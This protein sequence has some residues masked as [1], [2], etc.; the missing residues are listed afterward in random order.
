MRIQ[1]WTVL[2]SILA[3]HSQSTLAAP[4]E[5]VTV[6]LISQ[7]IPA[8]ISIIPPLVKQFSGGEDKDGQTGIQSS[9]GTDTTEPVDKSPGAVAK[10]VFTK[11]GE[12]LT[13]PF[14]SIF[15]GL[16]PNTA[17]ETGMGADGEFNIADLFEDPD[18]QREIIE[19]AL[20][21]GRSLPQN[22]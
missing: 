11:L 8:L 7:T 21:Y 6:A 3:L 18:F 19:R 9:N 13:K 12:A 22:V 16:D 17:A 1:V 5:P 20:Q 14:M 15:K 2:C 4:I 10:A